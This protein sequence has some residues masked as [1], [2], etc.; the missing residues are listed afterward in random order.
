[1]LTFGVVALGVTDVRRAAEFWGAALG[2]ELRED[3][4]GGWA[5]VLVPP[6]GAAGMA[7]ALQTSQTPLQDHPRLHF[8]LHVADAAEQAAEAERL[9]SLGAELVDWDSYP[10]DPDFVVLADPDGNRFCIV[11]LAHGTL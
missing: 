5:K 6:G 3:G 8:D 2:Y 11:D 7:I 4:F 10:D 1:M 9:V